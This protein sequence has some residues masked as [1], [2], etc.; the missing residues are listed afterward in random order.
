MAYLGESLQRRGDFRRVSRSC[1]RRARAQS[2]RVIPE[3]TEEWRGPPR[4]GSAIRG[5]SPLRRLGYL[6]DFTTDPRDFLHTAPSLD[7][8][9]LPRNAAVIPG[10]ALVGAGY[11]Q[12]PPKKRGL[13]KSSQIAQTEPMK[14]KVKISVADAQSK[15]VPRA[16][17]VCSR[18]PLQQTSAA[19]DFR[20]SRLPL[21]RLQG[22]LAIN[23]ASILCEN[24][25]SILCSSKLC[26]Q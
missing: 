10:P 8:P 9:A 23:P 4:R 14:Y 11:S 6:S 25:D 17:V 1:I 2:P 12:T 21:Q 19:A 7:G 20:C 15:G 5:G 18:L 26:S 22:V 16:K 24:L 3:S 13:H